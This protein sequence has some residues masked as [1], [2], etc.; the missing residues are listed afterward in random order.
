[1]AFHGLVGPAI[2]PDVSLHPTAGATLGLCVWLSSLSLGQKS[3]IS[4]SG[5]CG[6]F[7]HNAKLVVLL[8]M[9]SYQRQ[10]GLSSSAGKHGGRS[11]GVNVCAGLLWEQTWSCFGK[12]RWHVS[13]KMWGHEALLA[14]WLYSHEFQQLYLGWALGERNG[15]FVLREI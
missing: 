9:D 7:W 1:M 12:L 14:R 4:G 3:F 2:R 15:S 6:G 5:L 13:R 8:Y 10:V 11:H